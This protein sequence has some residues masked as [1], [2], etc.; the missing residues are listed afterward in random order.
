[1]SAPI[2]IAMCA[3]PLVADYLG[4][5]AG[6]WA[7]HVASMIDGARPSASAP[8]LVEDAGDIE[9]DSADQTANAL[10]RS[11]QRSAP[12]RL[13]RARGILVRAATVL[14][15][16]KAGARPSATPVPASGAQPAG[17]AFAGVGGL[18][19][20]VRDGD[21]LT[22]VSGAPASSVAAVINAVVAAR[23]ARARAVSAR[24]W[25]DGEPW[26]LVVE[27]PYVE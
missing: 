25:R 8:I 9:L 3:G 5:R 23:S 10:A 7:A 18:G 4:V 19:V 2:V 6:A 14:R 17:L 15:L 20:G 24:F 13:A 27:M 22:E 11:D 16:A 12:T 21:V 1:M 26:Q